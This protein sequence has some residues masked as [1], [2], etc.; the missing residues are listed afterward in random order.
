M[1][2]EIT[3]RIPGKKEVVATL[4]INGRRRRETKLYIALGVEHFN[5]QDSGTGDTAVFDSRTLAKVKGHIFLSPDER[6]FIQTCL[7]Y[8]KAEGIEIEFA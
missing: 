1:G 2:H 3:A 8:S 4:R 6:T 7:S 5:A